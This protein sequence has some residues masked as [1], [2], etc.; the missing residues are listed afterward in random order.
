MTTTDQKTGVR[1]SKEPI[2]SLSSY[3]K[4]DNEYGSG[5]MFGAYMT[6]GREGRLRVGDRLNAALRLA[7]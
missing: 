7:D 6:V 5:V 3:R 2:K 1:A 4:R